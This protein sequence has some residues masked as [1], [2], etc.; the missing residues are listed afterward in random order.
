MRSKQRPCE[1]GSSLLN[2][3]VWG[4]G[5]VAYLVGSAV[6]VGRGSLFDLERW[7]RI[8]ARDTDRPM[9]SVKRFREDVAGFDFDGIVP[10]SASEWGCVD[11]ADDAS[12]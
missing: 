4:S 2:R 1:R 12:R 11:G 3:H 9:V 6:L 8:V 7:Q 10:E 5:A